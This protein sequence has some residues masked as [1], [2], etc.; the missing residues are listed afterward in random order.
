MLVG[1]LCSETFVSDYISIIERVQIYCKLD[2]QY[3]W[4]FP[5]VHG[6][7][8][9]YA[10]S[11]LCTWDAV[12]INEEEPRTSVLLKQ[13]QV[14]F[15]ISKNYSK[16]TC[17]FCCCWTVHQSFR[18]RKR[19]LDVKKIAENILVI[20][21]SRPKIQHLRRSIEWCNDSVCPELLWV[22]HLSFYKTQ[23]IMPGWIRTENCGF[24]G[25]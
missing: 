11:L 21:Y 13:S 17:F 18:H 7:F 24:C 23:R 19:F 10:V 16:T 6:W 8:V 20:G 1:T 14:W 22:T 12:T 15:N 5:I 3:V 25:F 9:N 2:A 4:I